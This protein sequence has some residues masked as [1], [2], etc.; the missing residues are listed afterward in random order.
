MH[1][2]HIK[3]PDF[4]WI[5]QCLLKSEEFSS[6]L[7]T[8][9]HI[10]DG[11]NDDIM[12]PIMNLLADFYQFGADYFLKGKLSGEDV[13]EKLRNH[14]GE[15]YVGK[16]TGRMH[17]PEFTHH[18]IGCWPHSVNFGELC[19][20]SDPSVDIEITWKFKNLLTNSTSLHPPHNPQP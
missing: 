15:I 4:T 12:K 13:A 19:F 14:L 2:I 10:E 9:F 8:T 16:A 5:G 1:N 20:S 6:G 11:I 3:F 7:I 18:F 17:K